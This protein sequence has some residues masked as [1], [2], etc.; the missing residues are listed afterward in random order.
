MHNVYCRLYHLELLAAGCL[1]PGIVIVIVFVVVVVFVIV[2]V[3]SLHIVHCTTPPDVGKRL[4]NFWWPPL[5]RPLLF[6]P[7][8]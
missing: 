3:L 5:I 1:I 4:T 6:T 7:Q 2:I 8:L